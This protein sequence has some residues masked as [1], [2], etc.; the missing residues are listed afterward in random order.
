MQTLGKE[1]A[2]LQKEVELKTHSL[3]LLEERVQKSEVHQLSE[4]VNAM[5]ADLDAAQTTG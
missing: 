1:F 4:A 3:A 2:K 5:E